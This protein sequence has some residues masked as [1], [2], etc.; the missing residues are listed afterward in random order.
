MCLSSGDLHFLERVSPFY[1]YFCN[2]KC[3]SIMCKFARHVWW[4]GDVAL[5]ESVLMATR[6]TRNSAPAA[7]FKLYWVQ[8]LA[9]GAP[10][11]ISCL[12]IPITLNDFFPIL[13]LRKLYCHINP[14]YPMIENIIN[15]KIQSTDQFI[16]C[17]Y[18]MK[19]SMYKMHILY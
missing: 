13:F 15:L 10:S 11:G 14:N 2:I 6:N 9:N 19:V 17:Q 16:N 7:I 18:Y 1:S 12:Q 5:G 3:I 8:L 4:R